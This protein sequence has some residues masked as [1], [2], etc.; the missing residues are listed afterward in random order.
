MYILTSVG[1]CR[2]H[3]MMEGWNNCERS[4]LSSL[5]SFHIVLDNHTCFV[6]KTKYINLV[7]YIKQNS[8]S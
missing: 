8:F 6:Y 5:P 1:L 4:E 3:G 7:L 2:H